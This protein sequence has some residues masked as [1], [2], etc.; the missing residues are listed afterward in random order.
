MLVSLH[1][2][3]LG[4]ISFHIKQL[5]STIR[6]NIIF[7]SIQ[8][9]FKVFCISFGECLFQSFYFDRGRYR[10]AKIKTLLDF[11]LFSRRRQKR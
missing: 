10:K 3:F 1:D 7:L 9:L 6:Q 4:I 5:Y 11:D 8:M 2:V